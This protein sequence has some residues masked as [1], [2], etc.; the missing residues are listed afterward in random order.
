MLCSIAKSAAL[1]ERRGVSRPMQHPDDHDG[2]I[3]RDI[4]DGVG[5]MECHAQARRELFAPGTGQRKVPQRLAGGLD[6]RDVTGR[7]AGR[8]L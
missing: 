1:R 5:S 2:I 7:D 3:E 6:R 8:S 4:V